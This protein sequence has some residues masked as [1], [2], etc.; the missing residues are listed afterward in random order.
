LIGDWGRAVLCIW[1]Q[2][3]I[4]KIHTHFKAYIAVFDAKNRFIEDISDRSEPGEY[5]L[6]QGNFL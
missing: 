4:I 2:K 5:S 3:K 1:N 6:G